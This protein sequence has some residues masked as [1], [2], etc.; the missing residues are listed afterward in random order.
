MK[1]KVEFEYSKIDN[2]NNCILHNNDSR[3]MWCAVQDG[4]EPFMNSLGYSEVLWQEAVDTLMQNCPLV[5][6]E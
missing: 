1:Y 2:C 4:S 5:V 6:V 3:V